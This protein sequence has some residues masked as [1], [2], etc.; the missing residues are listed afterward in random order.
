MD[1]LA[2]IVVHSSEAACVLAGP[3]GRQART[4]LG[5]RWMHKRVSGGQGFDTCADHRLWHHSLPWDS[6]TLS[7]ERGYCRRVQTEH[8]ESGQEGAA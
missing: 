3:A 1:M 6:C 2:A 5:W 4:A 8:P 7:V